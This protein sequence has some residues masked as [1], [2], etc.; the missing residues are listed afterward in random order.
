MNER[1][2]DRED[3]WSS[4]QRRGFIVSLCLNSSQSC[5]QPKESLVSA[6]EALL[7]HPL[8]GSEV[9]RQR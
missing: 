3:G 8:L 4:E 6:E 5:S 9:L 1:W 7:F 2:E